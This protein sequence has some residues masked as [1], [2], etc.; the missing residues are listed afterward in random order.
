[1]EDYVMSM[2]VGN[3]HLINIV[4]DFIFSEGILT[5][6]PRIQEYKWVSQPGNELKRYLS[7]QEVRKLVVL[8]RAG[9]NSIKRILIYYQLRRHVSE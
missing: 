1:V 6:D 2:T 4:A 9:G 3:A 5:F 7:E 8:E